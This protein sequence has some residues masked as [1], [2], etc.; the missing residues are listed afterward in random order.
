M[1]DKDE[2]IQTDIDSED[3]CYTGCQNVSHNQ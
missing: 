2:E 1:C 3:N